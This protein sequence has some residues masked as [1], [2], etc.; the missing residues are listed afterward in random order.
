MYRRG[1]VAYG[2]VEKII[3]ACWKTNPWVIEG[4]DQ[5]ESRSETA[6]ERKVKPL[7]SI[8]FWRKIGEADRRR[9]VGRFPGL[10]LRIRDSQAWDQPVACEKGYDSL[11]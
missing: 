1:G 7:A 9:L 2:A 5:D 8:A 3:G 4:D 11:P 10:I 6:W